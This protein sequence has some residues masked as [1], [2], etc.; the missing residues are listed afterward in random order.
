MEGV[1]VK[2]EDSGDIAVEFVTEGIEY[3]HPSVE[4]H[5][6]FSPGLEDDLMYDEEDD[7][8][9]G[10]YDDMEEDEGEHH[11]EQSGVEGE[12]FMWV[13]WRFCVKLSFSILVHAFVRVIAWLFV[14]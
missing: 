9:Q 11:A 6:E 12:S 3:E 5:H 1:S 8:E 10:E 7:L 14:I 2:T 13:S 4:Q